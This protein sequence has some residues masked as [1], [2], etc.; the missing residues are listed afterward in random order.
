VARARQWPAR[1]LAGTTAAHRQGWGAAIT[2]CTG[3]GSRGFI[4]HELHPSVARTT[5]KGAR[6]Q[7]RCTRALP[8]ARPDGPCGLTT[9]PERVGL[10]PRARP[11]PVGRGFFPKYF[12]VHK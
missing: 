4:G 8:R 12:S 7:R 1:S 11:N 6:Q 2:G 9:G 5:K 3:L 10:G